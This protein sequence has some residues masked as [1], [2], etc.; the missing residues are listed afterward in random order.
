MGPNP[1]SLNIVVVSNYTQHF[2]IY[3]KKLYTTQE[4]HQ[5]AAVCSLHCIRI[6]R[7]LIEMNSLKLIK[8]LLLQKQQI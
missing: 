8:K 6:L 2:N 5:H 7:D 1:D 3:K 4:I